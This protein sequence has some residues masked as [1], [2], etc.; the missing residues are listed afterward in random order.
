[1]AEEKGGDGKR[2]HVNIQAS[3]D[4]IA[5]PDAMFGKLLIINAKV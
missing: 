1:M 3:A 4:S 5:N 2:A